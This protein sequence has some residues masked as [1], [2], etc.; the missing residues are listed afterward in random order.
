MTYFEDVCAHLACDDGT[1]SGNKTRNTDHC[2]FIF[3][4][5]STAAEGIKSDTRECA[6]ARDGGTYCEL[7]LEIKS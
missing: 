3:H 6:Q 4:T 1:K 5:I 2:L 7:Y